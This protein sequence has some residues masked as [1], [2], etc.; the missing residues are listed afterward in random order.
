MV[1]PVIIG[2]H[3]WV[4]AATIEVTPQ[5][6]EVS[7]KRRVFK[8]AEGRHIRALETYC[9]TCNRGYQEAAG[10]VCEISQVHKG[11]PIDTRK[12]KTSTAP[13]QTLTGSDR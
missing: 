2:E 11:G 9:A 12:R 7:V 4:V 6:A 5:E 3:T 8:A 1:A 10:T 13:A